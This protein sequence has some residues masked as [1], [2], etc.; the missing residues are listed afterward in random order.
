MGGQTAELQQEQVVED[1]GP[2][3]KKRRKRKKKTRARLSKLVPRT[4]LL[5]SLPSAPPQQPVP[6][7]ELW[8]DYR[9]WTE[10][11][12]LQQERAASEELLLPLRERLRAVEKQIG[13]E[14]RAAN[15]LRA[16]ILRNRETIQRLMD[17]EQQ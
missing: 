11:K 7:G 14:C 2:S 10:R 15:A 8:A 1:G 16:A 3:R 17:S 12:E 6:E 5:S 13:E 4:T 9:I